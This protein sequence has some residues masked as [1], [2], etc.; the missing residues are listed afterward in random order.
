MYTVNKNYMGINFNK[1]TDGQPGGFWE[2]FKGQG[3]KCWKDEA[4][5]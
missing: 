5:T 2:M 4:L 1:K 3:E